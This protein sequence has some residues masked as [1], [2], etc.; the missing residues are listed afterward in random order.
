MSAPAEAHQPEVPWTTRREDAEAQCVKLAQQPGD[1]TAIAK[2]LHYAGDPKWEVRK[3]VAENMAAFPMDLFTQLSTTFASERNALVAAAFQRSLSRRSPIADLSPAHADLVQGEFERLAR[4]F[5]PE[6]ADAAFKFAERCTFLHIRSAVHDIK[7]ILTYLKLDPDAIISDPG[8]TRHRSKIQRFKKGRDYLHRLQE[9]M[10]AYSSPLDLRLQ[11]EDLVEMSH[12]AITAAR[13][14][15]EKEGVDST[16]VECMVEAADPVVVPVS[17]FHMAMV[18]TNLVKNGIQAHAKT[19]KR[20]DAGRVV[21]R[22]ERVEDSVTI[23]LSDK[24]RG[25]A[26][27]DLQKLVQ[28]IPGGTAKRGGMGYGLPI[29]RRYVQEHAGSIQVESQENEGTT[30]TITIPAPGHQ[31]D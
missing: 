12:E 22:I 18:L 21:I 27:T 19:D 28:F 6:A 17:R 26:P 11:A 14:Q 29:C 16:L 23:K 3:V 20:H 4:K 31:V 15:V 24:G 10:D 8:D 1:E 5:G 30:V 7:N 2:V 13:D 25:I 9:M